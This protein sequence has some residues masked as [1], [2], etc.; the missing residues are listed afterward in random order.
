MVQQSFLRIFIIGVLVTNLGEAAETGKDIDSAAIRLAIVSGLSEITEAA[1]GSASERSCFTCH[2]QA[3]PILALSKA[4][5]KG[6]DIDSSVL[7]AQLEHTLAF[8]RSG[9]EKYLDGRG[10][11]GKTDTA[12]Y[13]L[14]ALAAGGTNPNET[15]DFVV[16]WLIDYQADQESWTCTSHR[17]PSEASD[18]TTSYLALSAIHI[19]GQHI[20]EQRSMPR[21]RKAEQWIQRQKPINTE[22][23]VFKM[24]SLHLLKASPESIRTLSEELLMLQQADGGWSQLNKSSSDAYATGIVLAG[25][26]SCGVLEPQSSAYQKGIQYLLQTQKPDGTWHVISRSKPF[27]TYFE[28]GFPHGDDQFISSSATCWAI[29]ALLEA[30]P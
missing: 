27:Q 4:Q 25:L 6:I 28:T 10:Q 23:R 18:F 12:G 1:T 5:A 14:L 24:R 3:H 16:D 19:Y 30:L 26:A 7:A 8:L 17:P 22:D 13:A 29:L 9:K 2:H 21:I 20:P 11:G 15:T